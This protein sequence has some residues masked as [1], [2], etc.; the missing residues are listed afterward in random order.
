M[1]PRPA[2]PRG[3]GSRGDGR[4]RAQNTSTCLAAARVLSSFEVAKAI[5]G[6]FEVFRAMGAAG[7]AAVGSA[8]PVP[9][10]RRPMCVYIYI[11]IYIHIHTYVYI[12]IY[13]YIHIRSPEDPRLSLAGM[14]AGHQGESGLNMFIYIY[15]Y[16]CIHIC[17]YTYIYIYMLCVHI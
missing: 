4:G 14:A 7:L 2:A 1:C 3:P 16:I 8:R 12:Y 5:S 10:R 13:I 9:G 15:I 17:V 11:Y 6:Q